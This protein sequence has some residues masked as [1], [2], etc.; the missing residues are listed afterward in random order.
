MSF[1]LPLG[2]L[3]LSSLDDVSAVSDVDDYVDV[4]LPTYLPTTTLP[5]TTISILSSR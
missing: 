5:T 4:L 2:N 3:M 1:G